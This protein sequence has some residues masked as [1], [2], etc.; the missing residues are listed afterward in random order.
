[1]MLETILDELFP[2]GHSVRLAGKTITG[3]AATPLGTVA[4]LGTTDAAAMDHVIALGLS[5]FILETVAH[6]PE[7]PFVYLV[8]TS[9][10][11]LSRSEELLCLNGSLAHLAECVDLARRR[12]HPSLS[13][14]T[15]NAVSGG[16]LSYGLMAD[17]VFALNDTQVR[18]MDLR[19]MSRVTKIEHERLVELAGHSPIFAPGAENYVQMGAVEAVLG[20]PSA[21]WLVGALTALKQEAV[22]RDHR[23]ESG[24]SRGGRLLAKP[25]ALSIQPAPGT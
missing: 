6:H 17:R 20:L 13:L 1:M 15:A 25:I 8:D 9:G 5:A 22:L 14:V 23:M 18:V 21:D 4:V 24:F 2:D 10:Q 19:A 11:A 7:R 16:F 12:G 3:E